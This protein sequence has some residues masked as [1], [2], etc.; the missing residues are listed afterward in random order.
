MFTILHT[1]EGTSLPHA[2]AVTWQSKQPQ[3]SAIFSFHSIEM[4]TLLTVVVRNLEI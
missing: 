4:M 3:C 2:A 1:Q